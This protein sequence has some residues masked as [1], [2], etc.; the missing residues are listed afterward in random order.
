MG[1]AAHLT[2]SSLHEGASAY[3]RNDSVAADDVGSKWSLSAFWRHVEGMGGGGPA[4][5]AALRREIETLVVKTVLAAE[6]G[7]RQANEQL[8]RQMDSTRPCGADAADVGGFDAR[9]FEVFGFDV[10]VDEQLKPWLLE[11]NT[12]PSVACASPLDMDIKTA[13]LTDLLNVVGIA[14][15][16]PAAHSTAAGAARNTDSRWESRLSAFESERGAAGELTAEERAT[17][18][19][20]EAEAA[21]ASGSGA[22]CLYP[23]AETVSSYER[24]W[25]PS[26]ENQLLASWVKHRA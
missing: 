20:F 8:Q 6:P 2:N 5:V 17:I 19:S 4:A 10:L 23:L 12:S 15:P 25:E 16:D 7:M 1:T 3:A 9:C 24:L 21:R 13:V 22:R 11:V 26:G 14:V 18:R